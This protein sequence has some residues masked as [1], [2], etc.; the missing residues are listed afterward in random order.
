MCISIEK[1]AECKYSVCRGTQCGFISLENLAEHGVCVPDIIKRKCSFASD[2]ERFIIN[3]APRD[4]VLQYLSFLRKEEL[5]NIGDKV[6]TLRSGFGGSCFVIR[7]VSDIKEGYIWLTKENGEGS[8][9]SDITVW[10]KELFVLDN[11]Q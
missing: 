4:L 7:K 6:L 3:D 11:N 10:Y 2:A 5:P 9:I 8:Y 1:C